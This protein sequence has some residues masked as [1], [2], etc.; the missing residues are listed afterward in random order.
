MSNLHHYLESY[1]VEDFKKEYQRYLSLRNPGGYCPFKDIDINNELFYRDLNK[2]LKKTLGSEELKF[3]V[4]K[5]NSNFTIEVTIKVQDKEDKIFYLTSDQFGFSAPRNNGIGT[6]GV[7]WGENKNH[8]YARYLRA[9]CNESGAEDMK[10][11]KIEFVTECI[12]ETRTIGGS[13]LWP[14]VKTKGKWKSMYNMQR[15]VGCYIEDRVDITL[16]EIKCFYKA[17]SE[18][19]GKYGIFEEEYEAFKKIYEKGYP[20]NILFKKQK[21]PDEEK[22]AIY[23]WLKIFETFGNYVDKLKFEPSFVMKKEDGQYLILDMESETPS[24]LNDD[25]IEEIRK[26]K[27]QKEKD[28]DQEVERHRALCTLLNNVKNGTIRRS[29]AIEKLLNEGQE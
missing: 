19:R 6:A 14:K 22:R 10:M 8:Q 4:F 24:E 27:K 23:Q 18:V 2:F 25:K 7:A 15:G 21:Q 12:Y 20:D 1:A 9:G 13:F 17:Y 11:K 29:E 5:I 3:E 26:Q 16:Y 28:K